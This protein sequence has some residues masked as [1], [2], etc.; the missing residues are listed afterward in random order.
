[1]YYLTIYRDRYPV[2]HRVS[3]AHMKRTGAT[4]ELWPLVGQQF[5]DR[6]LFF[7][8]CVICRPTGKKAA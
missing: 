2:L 4:P 6:G 5:V 8:A 7:V 1:M 3:C